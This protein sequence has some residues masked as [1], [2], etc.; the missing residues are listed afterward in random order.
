MVYRVTYRTFSPSG[1]STVY[2]LLVP[3]PLTVEFPS[4]AYT[5][6]LESVLSAGRHELVAHDARRAVWPAI[7]PVYHSR[8]LLELAVF[9]SGVPVRPATIGDV[10]MRRLL[11]EGRAERV[12]SSVVDAL[13][14]RAQAEPERP[15]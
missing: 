12:D 13:E 7:G 9:T 8:E 2:L 4:V 1:P 11:K 15:S 10:I 6:H 3:L 5:L 14:R